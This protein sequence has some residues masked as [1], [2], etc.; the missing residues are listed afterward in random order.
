MLNQELRA[1]GLQHLVLFPQVT[2]KERQNDATRT[3]NRIVRAL[4]LSAISLKKAGEA[5]H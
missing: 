5:H 2:V 4:R 1:F 3:A